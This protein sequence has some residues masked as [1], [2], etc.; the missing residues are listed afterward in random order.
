MLPYLLSQKFLLS[1]VDGSYYIST[2]RRGIDWGEVTPARQT[3][4]EVLFSFSCAAR[5]HVGASFPVILT[6]KML[7]G[8]YLL[9][10]SG[11]TSVPSP[12]PRTCRSRPEWMVHVRT[13]VDDPP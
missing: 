12:L 13:W 8:A 11:G 4:L 10:F 7:R 5:D 3:I 9:S 6:S 1:S 2:I